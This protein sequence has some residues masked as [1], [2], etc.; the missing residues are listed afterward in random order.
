MSL[1]NDQNLIIPLRECQNDLDQSECCC[2]LKKQ[3]TA[4]IQIYET[5][6]CTR[7]CKI[8]NF[9]RTQYNAKGRNNWYPADN[10]ERDAQAAQQEVENNP[11]ALSPNNVTGFVTHQTPCMTCGRFG[12]ESS[13]CRMRNEICFNCNMAGHISRVCRLPQAHR[14]Q[15]AL[16]D[17]QINILSRFEERLDQLQAQIDQSK[18]AQKIK[19][20]NSEETK[21]RVTDP[22]LNISQ[23]SQ[24]QNPEEN[25]S[26]FKNDESAIPGLGIYLTPEFKIQDKSIYINCLVDSGSQI[27][28]LLPE[29]FLP[30]GDY[31]YMPHLFAR[32]NSLTGHSVEVKGDL[33]I[34]VRN[35]DVITNERV[36]VIAKSVPLNAGIVGMPYL[37]K[38]G[39]KIDFD[40][41][42]VTL[43]D[44]KLTTNFVNCDMFRN[45]MFE[46]I[47][48]RRDTKHMLDEHKKRQ[49]VQRL[50]EWLCNSIEGNKLL[51]KCSNREKQS[52]EPHSWNLEELFAINSDVSKINPTIAMINNVKIKQKREWFTHYNKCDDIIE[53]FK[54]K[55]VFTKMYGESHS[56]HTICLL[57]ERGNEIAPEVKTMEGITGASVNGMAPL[58]LEYQVPTVLI[59]EASTVPTKIRAELQDLILD[60]P[61]IIENN[62]EQKV[63]PQARRNARRAL[64]Y[65]NDKATGDNLG[66]RFKPAT[67]GEQSE[68]SDADSPGVSK[69]DVMSHNLCSR[70]SQLCGIHTLLL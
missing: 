8:H 16:T 9:T 64:I 67:R 33:Y 30:P 13:N 19:E 35:K 12:H 38:S 59:L 6:L 32:V 55:G 61:A 51:E 42:E 52:V 54:E 41:E 22:E 39:A 5:I 10:N 20:A 53:P 25:S 57:C 46:Q 34:P 65:S 50:E 68:A 4:M 44:E 58:V 27:N 31:D 18:T 17:P 43:N 29:K 14:Q 70:A 26:K 60:P 66:A 21:T 63:S 49:T 2:Y 1:I 24:G 47:S 69:I 15:I 62:A 28:F 56:R 37:L 7:E 11:H 36:T 40:T 48:A 23:I 45:S 3:A